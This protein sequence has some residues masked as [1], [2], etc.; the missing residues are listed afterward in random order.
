VLFW[1]ESEDE[2]IEGEGK[3]EMIFCGEAFWKKKKEMGEG[4]DGW[5]NEL[6]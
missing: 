4:E 5:E 2:R 6:D 1:N 3:Y